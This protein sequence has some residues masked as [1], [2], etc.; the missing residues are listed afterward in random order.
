MISP[1]LSLD[2]IVTCRFLVTVVVEL[3]FSK[4]RGRRAETIFKKVA[5]VVKKVIFKKDYTAMKSS[6]KAKKQGIYPQL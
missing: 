4:G 2:D 6:T 1:H 5:E 3:V